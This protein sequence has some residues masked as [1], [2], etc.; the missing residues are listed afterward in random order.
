MRIEKADSPTVLPQNSFSNYYTKTFRERYMQSRFKSYGL[1]KILDSE[2]AEH[3]EEIEAT[4][5]LSNNVNKLIDEN[6]NAPR[7]DFYR[8]AAYMK[9]YGEEFG[10]IRFTQLAKK[11]HDYFKED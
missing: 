1:Q 9:E 6:N 11:V 7:F 8:F 2:I 5:A 4:V 10:R 3:K